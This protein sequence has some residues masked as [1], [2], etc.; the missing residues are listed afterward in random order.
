MSKWSGKNVWITGGG[1][2]LGKA[3][4]LEFARQGANVAVSGRREGRLQEVTKEVEALGGRGLAVVLD[5]TDESAV[6][7]AAKDVAQAFGGID[8]T[9]A[10]AGFGVAGKVVDLS[11]EDWRRQ[12]DVNVVGAAITAKHALP[13]LQASSGRI[14]LIGS[15]MGMMVAPKSGAYAASKYALRAIGQTLSL[16]LHGTGVSCTTIHPGFVESEIAKVD[17][18]GVYHEERRDPRPAKLMWKADDAAK[19]MVAAIHRRTREYTFTWHG[20]FGAA[21]GKHAPGLTH[22]VISRFGK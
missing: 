5:V 20:K 17:N 10:N 8:V 18:K 6:E 16:E 14:A 21:M 12:F 13:F 19:V 4:A 15:V 22:F 3:M 7:Q 9:V 2:G 11:A 1:T